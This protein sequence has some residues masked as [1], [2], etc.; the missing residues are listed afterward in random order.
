MI[1]YVINL[2]SRHTLRVIGCLIISERNIIVIYNAIVLGLDDQTI[3]TNY[4]CI[5]FVHVWLTSVPNIMYVSMICSIVF[6][7]DWNKACRIAIN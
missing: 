6:Q 2:E 7:S 1:N 5:Q 3:P 4:Y